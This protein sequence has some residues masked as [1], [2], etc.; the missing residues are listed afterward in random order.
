MICL[1]IGNIF[2]ISTPESGKDSTARAVTIIVDVNGGGNYTTIQEAVNEA[3]PGDTIYVKSGSYSEQ[4]VI[5]KSLTLI[6]SGSENTTI[7]GDYLNNVIFVTA[8][9]VV[10]EGFCISR[11]GNS[12][13]YLSDVQGCSVVNCTLTKNSYGIS[14]EE[15]LNNVISN[16]TCTINTYG[17]YALSTYN[18]TIKNNN[19][20]NN[21]HVGIYLKMANHNYVIN[22]TCK[23]NNGNEESLLDEEIRNCG[24]YLVN[25]NENIIS[26]N[27]CTL[28]YNY[29][30]LATLSD[31]NE[32][33]DNVCLVNGFGIYD[34]TCRDNWIENNTCEKSTV[35]GLILMFSDNCTVMRNTCDSNY[36]NGIHI[37]HSSFAHVSQNNLLN[38]YINGIYSV[39]SQCSIRENTCETNKF[40]GI[41]VIGSEIDLVDNI[42]NSNGNNGI[43]I[44]QSQVNS[45][46]SNNTCNFNNYS[47]IAHTGNFP[48]ILSNSICNENGYYGIYLSFSSFATIINNTCSENGY[49]GI[50][51]SFSKDNW[52]GM[53]SCTMN[54]VG[55]YLSEQSVENDI[56]ENEC[57][58]NEA[59]GISLVRRCS[60]NSIS[61]NKCYTNKGDGIALIASHCNIVD[62]NEIFSN[63]A[64]GIMVSSSTSNMIFLNDIGANKDLGISLGSPLKNH[65]FQNNLTGNNEGS[66]QAYD[67]FA[68]NIWDNGVSRGNFWSDYSIRY[69]EASI[70]GNIWSSPYII[71]TSGSYQTQDKYP[72]V[73]FKPKDDKTP[74][75]LM[76]ENFIAN[77]STGDQFNIS[78]TMNDNVG[79]NSAFLVYGFDASEYLMETMETSDDNNW[80]KEISIPDNVASM[81]YSYLAMDDEANVLLTGSMLIYVDDND[82]PIAKASSDSEIWEGNFAKLDGGGSRDN[83][84]IVKYEWI[85]EDHDGERKK[86]G[87]ASSATFNFPG[88]YKVTLRVEDAA[89]NWDNDSLFVEVK[90]F[91][92]GV[93]VFPNE[94]INWCIPI[95]LLMAICIVCIIISSLIRRRKRRVRFII[96]DSK[97]EYRS[98]EVQIPSEKEVDKTVKRVIRN[99]KKTGLGKTKRRK[100]SH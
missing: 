22:N 13:I 72:L 98:S 33:R 25:C 42:C 94:R 30:I 81:N 95:L 69:S 88:T 71:D 76:E 15:G 78:M 93:E 20:S 4:I 46:V 63:Q 68:S 3:D 61:R 97:A 80:Y 11:A 31:S 27:I 48:L 29:G 2:I 5:D 7:M 41:I 77:A 44:Y 87:I 56:I 90:E 73:S 67:E 39:Y 96:K 51:L 26:N 62:S 47:G 12:A 37:F 38:N 92:P 65:I 34:N 23:S 91:P 21:S 40:E 32:I 55:I 64:K 43:N 82:K 14:L 1:I 53:N 70:N 79:V 86:E 36:E 24:I 17:I 85:I 28:N 66:I 89:G 6:G 83:I 75:Y 58:M 16:N 10:I 57:S 84:G 49:Y 19:I 52:I 9:N 35:D 8:D 59:A 45:D 60:L 54:E 74:P 18:N 100:K 99:K 50:R